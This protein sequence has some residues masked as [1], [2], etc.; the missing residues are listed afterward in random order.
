MSRQKQDVEIRFIMK[1]IP[2][3]AVDYVLNLAANLTQ[4][5]ASLKVIKEITFKLDIRQDMANS[6]EAA[7]NLI[8]FLNKWTQDS[9]TIPEDS[10]LTPETLKMEFRVDNTDMA[11][12]LSDA[13]FPASSD[14]YPIIA[15]NTIRA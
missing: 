1:G 4:F 7:M 13:G 6:E 12:K 9:L 3:Q 2:E 14:N 15:H 11:K 10:G 5:Q 8:R